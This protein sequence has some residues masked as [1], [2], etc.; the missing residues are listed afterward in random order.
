MKGAQ[1]EGQSSQSDVLV[2]NLLIL[3]HVVVCLPEAP[4][5]FG[6]NEEKTKENNN[7]ERKEKKVRTTRSLLANNKKRI[8]LPDFVSCFFLIQIVIGHGTSDGS[9]AGT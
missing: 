4:N 2:F 7:K 3:P 1:N 5:T 9:N 8:S 6:V